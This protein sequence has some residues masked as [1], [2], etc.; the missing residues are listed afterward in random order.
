MFGPFF[1][2]GW[3]FS[4]LILKH[5][6]HILNIVLTRYMYYRYMFLFYGLSVYSVNGIFWCR[7]LNFNNSPI[8]NFF[9]D[10][11][12]LCPI[13]E[14]LTY[15]KVIKMFCDFYQHLYFLTIDIR[16]CNLTVIDFWL[17][18][19]AGAKIHNFSYLAT[20][21]TQTMFSQLYHRVT[22]VINKLTV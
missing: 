1:L 17:Q 21:L 6:L 8:Y 5:C 3:N 11:W 10:G 22:F 15:F 2:L 4:L 14:T 16:I 19:E 7:V 13:L 9:L 18:C 12:S 20:Q